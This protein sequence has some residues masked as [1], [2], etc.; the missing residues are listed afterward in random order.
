[1]LNG[2]PPQA[3]PHPLIAQLGQNGGHV[4]GGQGRGGIEDWAGAGLPAEP[5]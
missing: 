1:L 3:G 2:E 4:L 5:G